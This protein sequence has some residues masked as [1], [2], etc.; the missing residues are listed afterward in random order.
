MKSILRVRILCAVRIE[1]RA[2]GRSRA[3]VA[4]NAM[5]PRGDVIRSIAI[6]EAAIGRC[7]FGAACRLI[8][9]L[10]ALK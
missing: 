2:K 1:D 4:K 9:L 7:A 6:E 3:A 5:D 10:V 8:P